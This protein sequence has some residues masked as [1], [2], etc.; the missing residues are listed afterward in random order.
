MTYFWY[1]FFGLAPSIIWLLIFLIQ[2]HHPESKRMILK[3]F[4]YGIIAAIFVVLIGIGWGVIFS[5]LFY[6]L[7]NLLIIPANILE[8]S[9]LAATILTTIAF[10]PVVEEIAKYLVVRWAV[11]RH[12]EFDEPI[13]AMIY[14]I[15]AALGLAAAE[16]TLFL[17]LN[18][19]GGFGPLGFAAIRF[20]GATILHALCS[21]LVGYYVAMSF[22][23][24]KNKARLIRKGLLMAIFL[25]GLF[26]FS[27]IMI[28]GGMKMLDSQ[29][30]VSN[31]FTL[32]VIF[33]IVLVSLLVGLAY[34]IINC[35]KKVKK[36]KSVC[37]I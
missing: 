23:D 34:F 30:S 17:F 11:I 15:V 32:I 8:V 7:D 35:F 16:N 26:N 13:D 31:G 33:S 3:I 10:S 6:L 20:V 12:P 36:L 21:G 19:T 29:S 28:G 4:F 9:V 37:K 22:F 24:L 18:I 14:M 27:I 5:Q 1:I 2:D 25:H